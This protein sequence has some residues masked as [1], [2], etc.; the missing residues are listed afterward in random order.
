LT[1]VYIS[2]KR[3]QHLQAY[4]EEYTFRF[5]R[6]KSEK[7]GLLFDNAVRVP[8]TTNEEIMGHHNRSQGNT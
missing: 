5:N 3:K 4:L 7:L 2:N 1:A 8:P 6:H